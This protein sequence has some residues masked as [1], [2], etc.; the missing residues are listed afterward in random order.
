MLPDPVRGVGFGTL[1]MV[2]RK[3]AFGESESELLVTE[4]SGGGGGGMCAAAGA[5]RKC[6]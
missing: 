5:T 3:G 2:N 4:V 6:H 1:A